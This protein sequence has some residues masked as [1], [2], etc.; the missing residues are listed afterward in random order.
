[1]LH[2]VLAGDEDSWGFIVQGIKAKAQ[3]FLPHR[4]QY[5]LSRPIRSGCNVVGA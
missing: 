3:E 2:A 5:T 4:D 1:M